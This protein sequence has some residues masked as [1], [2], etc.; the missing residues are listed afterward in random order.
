MSSELSDLGSVTEGAQHNVDS[1]QDRHTQKSVPKCKVKRGGFEYAQ[2]SENRGD[3]E[4][5]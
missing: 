5:N 4:K 1:S 3:T 2:D